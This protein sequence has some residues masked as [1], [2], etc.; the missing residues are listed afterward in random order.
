MREEKGSQRL[1]ARKSRP[2]EMGEKESEREKSRWR[3]RD[4]SER[5]TTYAG[6]QGK[7]SPIRTSSRR[8]G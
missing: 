3:A 1:S 6:K 7:N 2:E 8:S 5:K 4:Y